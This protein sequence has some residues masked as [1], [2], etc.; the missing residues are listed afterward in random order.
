MDR[1]DVI[2]VND[3]EPLF[4]EKPKVEVPIGPEFRYF[5]EYTIP[6]IG[7]L[8][9]AFPMLISGVVNKQPNITPI[10]SFVLIDGTEWKVDMGSNAQ[11]FFSPIFAT[12]I[13]T[14]VIVTIYKTIEV[15]ESVVNES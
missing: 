5:E 4:D 1:F 3:K 12:G 8:T 2:N 13:N 14:N 7:K 11:A 9:F 15:K 6:P 10:I